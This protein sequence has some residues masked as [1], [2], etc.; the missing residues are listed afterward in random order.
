MDLLTLFG[1]FFVPNSPKEGT[2][3]TREGPKFSWVSKLDALTVWVSHNRF[4]LTDKYEEIKNIAG[5]LHVNTVRSWNFSSAN[6][7]L[8]ERMK[9]KQTRLKS[10]LKRE[11]KCVE[12]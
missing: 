3:Y 12:K 8:K 1:S 11:K 2:D 9:E 7:C 4:G 10:Y 5:F 6:L